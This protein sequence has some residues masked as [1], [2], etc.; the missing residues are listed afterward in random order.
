MDSPT[1]DYGSCHLCGGQVMECRREQ[2]YRMNDR[3]VVVRNVPL[4]SCVSC[5]NSVARADVA[6]RIEDLIKSGNGQAVEVLAVDWPA[7]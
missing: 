5:G 6:K 2:A 7:A 3:W 1:Y 4:G